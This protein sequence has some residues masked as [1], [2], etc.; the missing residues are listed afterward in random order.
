MDVSTSYAYWELGKFKM[1]ELSD[2]RNGSGE[3]FGIQTNVD[4]E[5]KLGLVYGYSIGVSIKPCPHTIDCMKPSFYPFRNGL[6]YSIPAY[7]HPQE[8]Y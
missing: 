2:V 5:K 1:Y 3:N 7:S 6:V 8:M 4:D